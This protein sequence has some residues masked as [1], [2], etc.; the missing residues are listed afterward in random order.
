MKKKKLSELHDKYV[1]LAKVKK[2]HRIE[3]PV[4]LMKK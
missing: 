1:N 2:Q 3:T 4:N